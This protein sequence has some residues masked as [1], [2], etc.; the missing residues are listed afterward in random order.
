MYLGSYRCFLA[1]TTRAAFGAATFLGVTFLTTGFD[2]T[3]GLGK[4][5]FLL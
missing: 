5:V 3:F 2:V 4:T 1:L